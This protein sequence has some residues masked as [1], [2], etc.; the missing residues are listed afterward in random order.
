MVATGEVIFKDKEVKAF[1]NEITKRVNKVEQPAKAVWGLLT[2]RSYADVMDHFAKERGP[3]KKWKPIRRVG[4]ILQDTG[5]LRQGVTIASS[6]GLI[7]RGVLLIDKVPYAQT[8][9]EGSKKKKRPMRRFFWISDKAL[10]NMS[11]D[12]LKFLTK[13]VNV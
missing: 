8:H 11:K 6:P 1:L 2:A 4:Q 12:V 9:D 3:K 5:V 10:D 7:K 13:K